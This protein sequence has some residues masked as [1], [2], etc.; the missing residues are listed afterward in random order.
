MTKQLKEGFK[1][2]AYWNSYEIKSAKVIDQGKNIYKLP[3]ASFQG[4]KR[5]F[6]LAYFI[7]NNV[8]CQEGVKDNKKY[9]LPRV[10]L[11]ITTY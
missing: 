5:L 10:K 7:A 1:R 8:N 4:V 3:D 9:F 11:K 2:S 6:A